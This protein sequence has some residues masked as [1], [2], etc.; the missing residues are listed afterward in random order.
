MHLWSALA[1]GVLPCG[2]VY[3]QG[4]VIISRIE[5][6]GS[7][8]SLSQDVKNPVHLT[9]ATSGVFAGPSFTRFSSGPSR[10]S[11]TA[12]DQFSRANSGSRFNV[13]GTGLSG[14]ISH[15]YRCNHNPTFQA[16]LKPSTLPSWYTISILR[17]GNRFK[18]S[19]QPSDCA[20]NFAHRGLVWYSIV[21]TIASASACFCFASAVSFSSVA[22]LSACSLFTS[23]PVK[24]VPRPVSTVPP[25]KT[26]ANIWNRWF[27]PSAEFGKILIITALLC[28]EAVLLG[29]A[30]AIAV[31]I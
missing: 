1:V 15:L 8:G 19:S 29:T 22:I 25:T 3:G 6:S 10:V 21:R 24:Y 28:A 11:I 30:A 31:L 9:S 4:V 20:M 7:V 14:A 17:G 12:S 27:Q 18:S 5:P 16:S 13:E 2:Q 26:I 23:M